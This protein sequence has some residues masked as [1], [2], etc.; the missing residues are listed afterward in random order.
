MAIIKYRVEA[1][2]RWVGECQEDSIEARWQYEEVK[3]MN[4]PG[5]LLTREEAR[6]RIN[7]LGLVIVH[8]TDDGTIWDEPDEPFWEQNNGFYSRKRKNNHN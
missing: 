6:E 7:E 4:K 1:T 8:K 3:D 2:V 5:K